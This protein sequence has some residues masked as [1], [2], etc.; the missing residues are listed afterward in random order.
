MG[1]I[2]HNGHLSSTA[3]GGHR[4]RRPRI[5]RFQRNLEGR[6]RGMNGNATP[7][8]K[9][10]QLVAIPAW[11]FL[12]R[13]VRAEACPGSG[14]AWQI[15]PVAAKQENDRK[16][17]SISSRSLEQAWLKQHHAEYAGVWVALEGASLVARGSSARQVL[18]AARSK[19]YEQPLIVHVPNEPQLPFGGW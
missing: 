12:R 15:S 5:S 10:G 9:R 16:P 17:D 8:A 18:D 6:K 11:S 13:R 14:L 19:G 1:S 4:R 2:I 7:L 3:A